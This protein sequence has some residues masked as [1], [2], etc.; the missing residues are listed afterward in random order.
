[1]KNKLLQENSTLTPPSNK[2]LLAGQTVSFETYG[3]S[4][5]HADTRLMEHYA[6]TSGLHLVTA[7]KDS[8]VVVLNTCTVKGPTQTAIEKRI[9]ELESIGKTVVVAGCLSQ[10]DPQNELFKNKSLIGPDTLDSLPE[11]ISGSLQGSPIQITKR[12]KSPL[13]LVVRDEPPSSPFILS[14]SQG[15]LSSC[16]FCMTKLARGNL[17]SHSIRHLR[18]TAQEAIARGHRE[19]YL[20]SQDTSAYGIDIGVTLADLLSALIEI[21]GRF[22]IRIGMANPQH[23]HKFEDSLWKLLESEKLYRFLHIPLQSGSNTVLDHMRREHTA[24]DYLSLVTKGRSLFPDLTIATDII[25]GY[26]TETEEDHQATQSALLHSM[27]DVVNISRFWPRPKTRAA[28][29]TPLSGSLV[30]ARSSE[31]TKL[32]RRISRSRNRF[33]LDTQGQILV[34]EIQHDTARGGT[35]LIGRNSSYKQVI[36]VPSREQTFPAIGESI[37]CTINDYGTF[38]LRSF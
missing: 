4:A 9:R 10:A 12:K 38:D 18:D 20:T 11:A 27:P 25:C 35:R 5:N 19:V 32:F 16:S 2:P 7:E 15:C 23:F 33:W 24:E 34:T 31:T 1:M 14:I 8:D 3:C 22:K 30:K 29:L 26:P 6:E 28:A 21:K 13:P 36:V 17:R 37:S